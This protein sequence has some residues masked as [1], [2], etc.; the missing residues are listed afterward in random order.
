MHI[1]FLADVID[2]QNAGIHFYTSNLIKSLVDADKENT[3]SF[4]HQR[5]NSFFDE[6]KNYIIPSRKNLGYESFR[7]LYL[8]PKLLKKIKA[9]IVIE[10]CHIGPF[11]VPKNI[12]KITIIHDLTPLL[13]PQFHTRISVF[14]HRLL[15]GKTIKNANLILVPSETT[16]QD[17]LAR[18]KTSAEIVVT[19]EGVS[20][21][22]NGDNPQE[23]PANLAHIH[24]PYILFIGTIEPRKNLS[25]LIDSFSELK[26]SH[27]IPHKLI[28]GGGIG[29]RNTETLEKAKQSKDVVLTGYLTEQEKKY[30]YQNADMFVYP[31][32]Y[33]GF[34]LPPLEAMN[35]DI[36]VICS[37]GGSLKEIFSGHSLS[38]NPFDK[39]K[40]KR[41]ILTL[42]DNPELRDSLAKEGQ[43]YA[44]TFTWERTAKRVMEAMEKLR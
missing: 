16:K 32:I 40:L 23:K 10:P 30:L 14:T 28:L 21:Q 2:N 29:W 8:I 7:K 38:F 11:H 5:E 43:K 25:I 20:S 35:Y 12:K 19:S 9:D 15:L 36:P 39:E 4:I 42:I 33:E 26:K 27:K 24:A 31:S 34:G 6:L 44:A 41:H 3:Y 22:P 18:Y 1:V 13:F 37:T 17:I